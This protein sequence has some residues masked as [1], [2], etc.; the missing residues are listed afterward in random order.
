MSVAPNVEEGVRAG[1][2]KAEA[3]AIK[4][5]PIW[6]MSVFYL[7]SFPKPTFHTSQASMIL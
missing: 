6:A 4:F 3:D 5:A 2:K 1:L 7:G